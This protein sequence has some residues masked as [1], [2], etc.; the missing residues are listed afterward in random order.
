MKHSFGKIIGTACTVQPG[1][2]LYDLYLPEGEEDFGRETLKLMSKKLPVRTRIVTSYQEAIALTAEQ[3]AARD[4][5]EAVRKQQ[6]AAEAAA[7]AEAAASEEG[8]EGGTEAAPAT[9]AA[10]EEKP[11]EE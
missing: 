9:E 8:S 7:E 10:T 6:K 1:K 5:K 3:I 2:V 11:S 4:A